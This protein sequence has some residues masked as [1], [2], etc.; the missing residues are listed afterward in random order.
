MYTY[1]VGELYNPGVKV[2]PETPHLRL[3]GGAELVLFLDRPTSREI[4]AIRTG[5]AAFGWIDAEH[6]GILC[7]AFDDGV[8]W[9][10]VAYTPHR[11]MPLEAPL[12]QIAQG[13]NTM[14][15][16]VLVDASTGIIRAMRA[17][18]W[19]PQFAAAVHAT[20]T[21]IADAPFSSSAADQALDALYARYPDTVSLVNVG[22]NI[23]CRGDTIGGPGSDSASTISPTTEGWRTWPMS[24]PGKAYP[25]LLPELARWYVYPADSGHS[26][27][28]IPT[29]LYGSAAPKDL[30]VPVPV[31]TVLR[32]GWTIRDGWLVVPV[33]YDEALG[34]VV[35]EEDTQF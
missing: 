23:T 13:A 27:M 5:Q 11:D 31:R 14:L 33:E 9:S 29:S 20:V 22:A 12:F 2:W 25:G 15:W 30:L 26:L 18:C 35:P 24:V 3:R 21:R 1:T 4:T 8:P 6:T 19:P 34:L 28:A 7:Y 16:V 17:M 32:L 10:D